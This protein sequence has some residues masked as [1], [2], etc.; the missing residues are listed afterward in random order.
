MKWPSRIHTEAKLEELRGAE[1]LRGSVTQSIV[2]PQERW[3]HDGRGE[4]EKGKKGK[5]Q[6]GVKVYEKE[7][8]PTKFPSQRTG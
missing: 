7:V 8:N 1:H 4:D 3:E 6:Y 2:Q 5:K